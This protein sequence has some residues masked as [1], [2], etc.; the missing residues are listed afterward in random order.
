MMKQLYIGLAIWAIMILSWLG[1]I[2][3]LAIDKIR[4]RN[5]KHN[6]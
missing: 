3:K 1:M 2:V 4:S 5:D 6:S